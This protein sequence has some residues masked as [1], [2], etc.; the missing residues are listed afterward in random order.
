MSVRQS[1]K[2]PNRHSSFPL[3]LSFTHS[4]IEKGVF[5]PEMI[6]IIYKKTSYLHVHRSFENTKSVELIMFIT[7]SY[8]KKIHINKIELD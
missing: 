8:V 4:T 7:F 5:C 1:S 6:N 2:V 3:S